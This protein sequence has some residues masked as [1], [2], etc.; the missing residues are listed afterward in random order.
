MHFIAPKYTDIYIYIYVCMYLYVYTCIYTCGCF[1]LDL[2]LYSR[3][4][5]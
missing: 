3:S 1:N 4:P 5:Q 2:V